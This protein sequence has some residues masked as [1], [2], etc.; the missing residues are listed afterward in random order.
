MPVNSRYSDEKFE[1][2]MQDIIIT[3]EKHEADRDLSLMVLG[4]LVANIFV[5][6]VNENN[7]ANMVEQFCS[8]LKKTTN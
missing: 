8:V 6:Q 5:N 1:S 7:R 3:L 4:N 2:L